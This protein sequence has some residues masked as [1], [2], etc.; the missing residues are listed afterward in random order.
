MYITF[1]LRRLLSIGTGESHFSTCID[2]SE[3]AIPRV[4]VRLWPLCGIS[5][6]TIAELLLSTQPIPNCR[7]LSILHLVDPGKRLE[8]L[9]WI[10]LLKAGNLTS[11]T[12]RPLSAARGSAKA[13]VD[14]R[15]TP[16]TLSQETVRTF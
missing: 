12:S 15:L 3:L 9:G 6:V 13:V 5:F 10:L 8:P 4:V 2:N 7:A 16:L 11:A 14:L 1:N